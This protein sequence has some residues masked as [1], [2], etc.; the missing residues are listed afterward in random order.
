MVIALKKKMDVEYFI[1]GALCVAFS[2][3]CM[4][5][6][7]FTLPYVNVGGCAQYWLLPCI[8]KNKNG[9]ICKRIHYV[10]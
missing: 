2:G 1:R 8:I 4:L 6:N 3:H 5:S 9:K 10:S 7:N